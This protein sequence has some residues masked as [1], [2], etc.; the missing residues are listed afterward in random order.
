MPQHSVR[1]R[2]RKRVRAR[3]MSFADAFKS[4]TINKYLLLKCEK[5]LTA[6]KFIIVYADGGCCHSRRL[7]MSAGW[8][9]A[10][11]QTV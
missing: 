9:R 3:D 1:G 4:P 2:E 11:T 6:K 10:H 8:L 7:L 5:G